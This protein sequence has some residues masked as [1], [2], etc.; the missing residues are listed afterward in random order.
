MRRVE[1]A[2]GG[3]SAARLRICVGASALTKTKRL[4]RFATKE[5]GPLHLK[6]LNYIL[7]GVLGATAAS[8]ATY[9]LL[10]GGEGVEVAPMASVMTMAT[11]VPTPTPPPGPTA[12]ELEALHRE[13]IELAMQLAETRGKLEAAD[14]A[15]ARTSE[16]LEELRRPM[17]S[18]L[19]SSALRAE[20]KSG[21][22]V[23]TGG[24]RLPDGT[25][26]YAFVQPTVEPVEG[27]DQV[28]ITSEV[29]L[30]SDAMGEV[31]GLDNL[32]TNAA[33]TLQHGEVWMA[34]EQREVFAALDA[35]P[36]MRAV[37]YPGVTVRPGLSSVIELGDLKLKVTPTLGAD[38]KS[39]DFEV[40]LEQPQPVVGAETETGAETKAGTGGELG[41]PVIVVD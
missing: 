22:V 28:R 20:L 16:S 34:E 1:A 40:R 39:L 27:G 3:L 19:L 30:L 14:Q 9:R 17:T 24:Y 23:V 2:A 7:V 29:R 31:V 25:R 21:E 36:G 12:A 26:V 15:L 18:D 41:P 4:R 13:N 11:P 8:F 10:D 5:A 35:L 6:L 32:S 37:S 33:N 38:G